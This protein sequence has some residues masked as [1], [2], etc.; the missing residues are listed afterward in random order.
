MVLRE[1]AATCD[2]LSFRSL[3]ATSRGLRP[4][5]IRARFSSPPTDR[6]SGR[7]PHPKA[8]PNPCTKRMETPPPRPL[9]MASGSTFRSAV[10]DFGFIAPG[11]S[12]RFAVRTSLWDRGRVCSTLADMSRLFGA[13]PECVSRGRSKSLSEIATSGLTSFDEELVSFRTSSASSRMVN[14]TGL[15][16]LTGPVKE[17]GLSI[18]RTRPSIRSLTKQKERVWL[19]SPYSVIGSP[20]N[21]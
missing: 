2:F 20:A 10:A 17:G 3:A 13:I 16:R 14:S 11:T 15:P 19:P 18:K 7:P 5:E 8:D 9:R 12:P 1:L 21:A 4:S 6:S